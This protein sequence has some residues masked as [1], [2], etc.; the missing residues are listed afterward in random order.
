MGPW[1]IPV[2]RDNVTYVTFRTGTDVSASVGLRLQ[3]H[4]EPVDRCRESKLS[5]IQYSIFKA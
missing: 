3:K 2:T 4:I 1:A 5:D